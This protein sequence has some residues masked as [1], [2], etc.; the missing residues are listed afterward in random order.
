MVFGS[1]QNNMFY[2]YLTFH[3]DYLNLLYEQQKTTL[4]VINWI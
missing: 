1:L 4:I 2:N 3:N